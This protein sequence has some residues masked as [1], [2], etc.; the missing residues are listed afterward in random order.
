MTEGNL[1]QGAVYHSC[2][3][4]ITLGIHKSCMPSSSLWIHCSR[5]PRCNSHTRFNSK[6]VEIVSQESNSTKW[7]FAEFGN[8][9]TLTGFC[10]TYYRSQLLSFHSVANVFILVDDAATGSH[11]PSCDSCNPL[12]S[13]FFDHAAAT[14]NLAAPTLMLAA[15]SLISQLLNQDYTAGQSSRVRYG[16]CRTL[17]S[18]WFEPMKRLLSLLL[19]GLDPKTFVH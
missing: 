4:C 3:N 13:T 11:V 19:G 5:A 2:Y 10:Y 8:T 1:I 7:F 17:F 15:A 14:L 6:D 9:K 18:S 12:N 16:H